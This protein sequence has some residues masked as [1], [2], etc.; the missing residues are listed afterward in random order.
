MIWQ[1]KGYLLSINRYN[2][3]SSIAEFYTKKYGKVSGIIFGST[4]KKNKSYLMLGNNL[5]INFSSKTNT[6]IGNFKIEINKVNTPIY[7]NDR[8]KLTC[9]IYSMQIIRLLSGE[10][11]TNES[12][13]LL[14]DKLF[15][16][17]KSDNWIQSFIFW[18][19]S[20]FKNLGYEINFEDFSILKENNDKSIH[21]SKTDNA[22]IIPTFLINKSDKVNDY[23]EL[24]TGLNL[25]G[26]FLEKSILQENN[27]NVPYS[28]NEFISLIEEL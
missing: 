27:T 23:K 2:E 5:H 16:L 6:S 1:D 14:I 9:I 15:E 8:L 7:F 13:Y 18:E 28:R 3:N 22:K 17:I 11:Q 4:S 26:D 25:V 20:L 19:L 21:V 24:V 12:I 10:N